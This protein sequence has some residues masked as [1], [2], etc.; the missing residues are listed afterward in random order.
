LNKRQRH[1]IILSSLFILVLLIFNI[2]NEPFPVKNVNK[3]EVLKKVNESDGKMIKIPSDHLG[4]QWYISK[5]EKADEN[6]KQ[7]MKNKGWAFV[8]KESDSYF[9][10]GVQGNII[11]NRDVWKESYTIFRFPEGI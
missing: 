5:K 1:I 7:L 3:E 9:F 8:K 11:V 2:I 4:F 10:E 6:L